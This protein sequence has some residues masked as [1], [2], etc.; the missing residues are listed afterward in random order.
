MNE[1]DTVV[2]PS[3]R[4]AYLEWV[5]QEYNSDVRRQCAALIDHPMQDRSLHALTELAWEVYCL[6]RIEVFKAAGDAV[7]NSSIP[8]E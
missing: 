7:T 4:E 6:S 1:S 5:E 3:E 2:T 8:L